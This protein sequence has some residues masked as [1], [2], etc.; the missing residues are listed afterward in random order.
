MAAGCVRMRKPF[1]PVLRMLP[2]TTYAKDH[3]LIA[4]HSS[5]A[6]AIAKNDVEAAAALLVYLKEND[7]FPTP[8]QFDKVLQANT[9]TL[10]PAALDLL[11]EHGATAD[12]MLEGQ[13]NGVHGVFSLA[14]VAAHEG[15]TAL[16]FHL[17][18]RGITPVEERSVR[19]DTLL[20]TALSQ[21]HEQ[22]LAMAQGLLDRGA[23]LNGV[24][25]NGHTALHQAASALNL[26]SLGWLMSHGADPTIENL[27]GALAAE[28]VPD[29]ENGPMGQEV[30]CE[31]V[32]DALEAYRDTFEAGSPQMPST[33]AGLLPPPVPVLK[34]RGPKGAGA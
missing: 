18:D 26:P 29:P 11:V 10:A 1:T 19:G 12:F 22:A 21:E 28:L 8:E 9:K 27:A 31:A 25:L 33:F 5:F 7:R 16:L 13:S 23:D 34:L 30:Q 6:V 3:P 17:V 2:A 4:R 32:F 24:N 20:M 14:M 15:N